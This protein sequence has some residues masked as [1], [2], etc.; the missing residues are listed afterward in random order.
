M[1]A[2]PAY[3]PLERW[4]HEAICPDEDCFV[5]SMQ[6][7]EREIIFEIGAKEAGI[8]MGDQ[9]ND[10]GPFLLVA[11]DGRW[12]ICAD[13]AFLLVAGEEVMGAVKPMLGDV[14]NNSNAALFV[15]LLEQHCIPQLAELG[16]EPRTEYIEGVGYSREGPLHH[17]VIKVDGEQEAADDPVSVSLTLFRFCPQIDAFV[18]QFEPDDWLKNE[19]DEH[20]PQYVAQEAEDVEWTVASS[21]DATEIAPLVREAIIRAAQQLSE[22]PASLAEWVATYAGR[23]AYIHAAAAALVCD[24]REAALRYAQLAVSEA[25]ARGSGLID[26]DIATLEAMGLDVADR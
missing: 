24:D 15:E 7:P 21:Q 16:F 17:A 8:V 23:K 1:L 10:L 5:L 4:D 22:R 2:V 19:E 6:A 12:G 14:R 9:E 26:R 25:R 13:E 3:A 20:T 18:H 11:K